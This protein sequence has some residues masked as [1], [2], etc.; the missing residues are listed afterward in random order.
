[1]FL[2]CCVFTSVPCYQVVTDARHPMF[3]LPPALYNFITEHVRRPLIM[4]L[5]KVC[6][7]FVWLEIQEDFC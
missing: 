5:N 7:L 2:N 6:A 4:I 3:H 1:V